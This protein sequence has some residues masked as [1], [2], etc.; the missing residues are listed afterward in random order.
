[1][2]TVQGLL[3]S[4]GLTLTILIIAISKMNRELREIKK[5]V[6]GN[7]EREEAFK[8]EVKDTISREFLAMAFRGIR[9]ERVNNK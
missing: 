4:I 7:K 1:M 3:A 2:Q 8:K 9:L 5:V 6:E